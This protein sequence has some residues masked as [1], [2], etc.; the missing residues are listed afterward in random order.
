MVWVGVK[1]RAYCLSL[2]P[3]A[4]LSQHFKVGDVWLTALEAEGMTLMSGKGLLLCHPL[5]EG[6][7]ARWRGEGTGNLNVSVVTLVH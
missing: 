7:E 1:C 6:L 4:T 2:F 5:A 3:T